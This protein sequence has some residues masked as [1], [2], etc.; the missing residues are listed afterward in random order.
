MTTE[1]SGGS[2][3][4]S[5]RPAHALPPSAV[6]RARA[7]AERSTPRTSKPAW[8]SRAAMGRPMRPRPTKATGAGGSTGL[9]NP[10]FLHGLARDPEAVER[11]RQAAVDRD[12][13]KDLADLLLGEAVVE[14][15]ADMELQL[16]RT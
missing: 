10:R 8:I 4:A 2:D 1:H 9:L 12:L 16:V 7:S 3:K 13:E 5:A 11:R 14:R 6:S 15:A